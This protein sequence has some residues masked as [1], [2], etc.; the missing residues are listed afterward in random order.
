MW[1][2]GDFP[3]ALAAFERSLAILRRAGLENDPVVVNTTYPYALTLMDMANHEEALPLLE[4]ALELREA[5]LGPEH[6]AVGWLLYDLGRCYQETLRFDEARPLFER[7]LE[8]QTRALGRDHPNLM[9]PLRNLAML[10]RREQNYDLARARIER[11]LAIG[12][13]ALGEEHP[14]LVWVLSVYARVLNNQGEADRSLALLERAHRLAENTLGSAHLETARSFEMLG[15]HYYQL[16]DYDQALRQY[17][18]GLEVREQ[19]FGPGHP[20]LGWNLYDQACIL[21]LAG[22]SDAALSRLHSALDCGWANYRIHED[23]D[24]DSL[25][26][27]PEFEAIVE[28]VRNRLP[29][30]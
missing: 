23:G 14:D 2:I 15:F 24:L 4:R 22:D 17:R 19:I 3:N 13:G 25:R 27:N 6:S 7:A 28:E 18:R 16:H 11:A 29:S 9:M 20:A 8:I 30:A 10:D 12:E 1:R 26:G 21:A 5:Q